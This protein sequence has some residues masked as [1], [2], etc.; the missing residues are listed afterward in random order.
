[1]PTYN[2]I[3]RLPV[4]SPTIPEFSVTEI[5]EQPT[6]PIPQPTHPLPQ[7]LPPITQPPITTTKS[8][9]D[10]MLNQLNQKWIFDKENIEPP[11][12]K[13]KPHPQSDQSHKIPLELLLESASTSLIHK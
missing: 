3:N 4:N 2:V 12:P 8:K 6:Q 11:I 9:Y 5:L 10:E 13:F 7:P 1:L